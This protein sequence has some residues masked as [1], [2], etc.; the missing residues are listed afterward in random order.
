MKFILQ[1]KNYFFFV[2]STQSF[3]QFIY[4]EIPLLFNLSHFPFN[5]IILFPHFCLLITFFLSY[6]FQEL[7]FIYLPYLVLSV[8]F[9]HSLYLSNFFFLCCFFF[10]L[11]LFTFI[12][13]FALKAFV[14]QSYFSKSF[15]SFLFLLFLLFFFPSI[16]TFSFFHHYTF[17]FLFPQNQSLFFQNP[18]SFSFPLSNS[19]LLL[20]YTLN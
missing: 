11:L 20:P 2:F 3:F 6:F 19:L 10:L 7:T 4:P 13:F 18:I 8:S 17:P 5:L 9:F 16:S 12:F 14:F 15:F 1:I